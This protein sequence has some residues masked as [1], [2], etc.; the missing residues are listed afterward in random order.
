MLVLGS[1]RAVARAVLAVAAAGMLVASEAVPAAAVSPLSTIPGTL[2][3]W[4]DTVDGELGI[5]LARPAAA[6]AEPS[7]I[8]LGASVLPVAVNADQQVV[9]YNG[10]VWSNGTVTTS[11][12]PSS[13]PTATFTVPSDQDGTQINDSGVVV[14]EAIT[15][16][17]TGET[18]VPAYWNTASSSFTV[19]SLAGLTVN[20]QPATGGFFEAID[21]AG[22]AV[23]VV[24]NSSGSAGD[25][26]ANTAGL[27]VAGNDAMPT[28]ASQV[29]ASI[30]GTAIH[31][32]EGVSAG[33]EDANAS[34]SDTHPEVLI[35]RQTQTATTTNLYPS[36]GGAIGFADNGTLSGAVGAGAGLTPTVRT[37][38][39]SETSLSE[40]TG[41]DGPVTDVNA[42]GSAVGFVY[43]ETGPAVETG[44]I[45]SSSGT[46][47]DLLSQVSDPGS[48]TQLQ[49]EAINDVGYVVGTGQLNGVEHGFLIATAAPPTPPVVNSAGDGDA[50]SGGM[51]GCTTGNTVTVGGQ[52]VP[53]CTLRA[54]IQAENAGS[55]TAKSITF[56]LPASANGTIIPASA[57][58]AVTAAG[59][60]I[61]G[62]PGLGGVVLDGINVPGSSTVG[63]ELSGGG[64]GVDGLA[65]QVWSTA[66]KLDS[67]AGGDAVTGNRIGIAATG[68]GG[69]GVT[70]IGVDVEG[71]PNNTIGGPTAAAG[72]LISEVPL[73]V[74]ISGVASSG[75][76]VE[77]NLIGTDST[78]TQAAGDGGGIDVID[79]SGNT[80]GGPTSA[81]GTAPG[82]VIDGN[83][84]AQSFGVLIG[85]ETATATGN[86]VEGNIVGLLANGP[87]PAGT[88]AGFAIGVGSAGMT[89][90]TI[91]GGGSSGD[92]NVITG[93]TGA[94]VSVDGTST[95]GTQVLG[96]LIGTDPT[97]STLPGGRAIGVLVSGATHTTV[98]TPGAGAN[99]I[100]GNSGGGI[101]VVTAST[102]VT[103]FTVTPPLV[104]PGTNQTATTTMSTLISGNIIGPLA[105]GTSLWSGGPQ[106]VGINLAGIGDTAGPNNEVS[107]N[108]VGIAVGGSGESVVGNLIGT[109][110][111]GVLAL[112][113]GTGVN[114][115]GKNA[116]IGVPG[117]KA[118]TISGNLNDVVIAA[119]ATVEN[120]LIGTTSLGNAPIG[121][122]TGTLPEDLTGTYT[123]PVA[124]FA[125]AA[126]AGSQ[127]GGML[128]GF[129]NV[130]SGNP[131]DALVLDGAVL[132]QGNKIGVGA[133]GT[134]AV[135]NQGHGI[136]IDQQGTLG[137]TFP[138]GKG[139]TAA[140]GGNTIANNAQAGIDVL[141]GT[142]PVSMLSDSI[143]D[144]A[145]GGIVLGSGAN[146]GIKPPDLI[147][148]NQ[149][150][151][152]V[153]THPNDAGGSLQ[154]FVA[155]S[156]TA[157]SAQG[158]TLLRTL[159]V[160]YT[161]ILL[162]TLPLQP[163]GT[164]L[165]ATI[166][167]GSGA[168]APTSQFSTCVSVGPATTTIS[169][170]SSTATTSSTTV[171]L[172]ITVT[173][174]SG[175]STPCAVTTTGTL[176]SAT[177]TAA[178]TTSAKHRTTSTL[179]IGSDSLRVAAG[180]TAILKLKLTRHGLAL[181][182]SRHTLAVTLTVK[183]AKARHPTLTRRLTIRLTYSR[184]S[185]SKASDLIR[186]LPRDP[187]TPN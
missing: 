17:G 37:A 85:G 122:F 91:V 4:G 11:Q 103:D 109:N 119:N 96:N 134:T 97:G 157:T 98:G 130:I 75:N 99:V 159:A 136:L 178:R 139:T 115:T 173:C 164:E 13:A 36:E 179:T 135:P 68:T 79:A 46:D 107:G 18:V 110:P 186:R 10:S 82:N 38:S 27:F 181:L 34:E 183:I 145:G 83:G 62:G 111:S 59:V 113:N 118:N 166:T 106:P 58:P 180:A 149:T 140:A 187:T 26:S 131:A 60:T 44:L 146:G 30:D 54:A 155:N 143:Y 76:V 172:P 9:S 104:F 19:V 175:S 15:V 142:S 182:R 123:T 25:V 42:G 78:G 33:Y 21:A 72:N 125:Q 132:V 65:F 168:S 40:P 55:V 2:Q 5:S 84:A 28:G 71:S 7:I 144:N 81:P 77:G 23:G 163:V 148:A 94:E 150:T 56:A 53:E 147:A 169:S 50:I 105:A 153:L 93:A 1:R 167:H 124:V 14:G 141:A 126:A 32:L 127:I 45:W 90:G 120:N 48:W 162:P 138:G 47:S 49:P 35:D 24:Y 61:D 3:S 158:R 88:V 12:A 95:T 51:Q 22:D 92:G 161:G 43:N 137:A 66:I 156:C 74:L 63:L 116:Q 185:E 184:P 151:L 39:G 174:S 121:P 20:S 57:L 87:E 89:S 69:E 129:G 112:P 52:Q 64:D 133:N 108:E 176:T 170:P 154:I 6:A 80:I 117:T 152:Q 114:I 101:S 128:P 70:G 100:A 29:L 177:A 67:A 41:E 31:S 165:T 102:L 8:D 86:T 171:T 16:G 73:A 160:P